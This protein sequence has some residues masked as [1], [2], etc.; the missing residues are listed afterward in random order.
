MLRSEGRAM[1]QLI[2][3]PWSSEP[4]SEAVQEPG[5]DA[6]G[7]AERAGD[8]VGSALARA[9]QDP[10]VGSI[11]SQCFLPRIYRPKFDE[12]REGA[13]IVQEALSWWFQPLSLSNP[14]LAV[15]VPDDGTEGNYIGLFRRVA[16]DD[17]TFLMP[18]MI[19]F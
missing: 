7:L 18:T 1:N 8:V 5:I 2:A 11:V 4:L 15:L 12:L 10:A 9:L 19:T 16:A 13:P 17:A 6:S 3:L 14:D